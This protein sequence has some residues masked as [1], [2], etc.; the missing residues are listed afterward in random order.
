MFAEPE[1]LS[2]SPWGTDGLLSSFDFTR[3]CVNDNFELGVPTLDVESDRCRTISPEFG[4]SCSQS[5]NSSQYSEEF[6]FDIVCSSND[7]NRLISDHDYQSTSSSLLL[8][9]NFDLLDNL[10]PF[11]DG[12]LPYTLMNECEYEDSE[13]TNASSPPSPKAKAT[14]PTNPLADNTLWSDMSVD[15]QQIAIEY[16]TNI[17]SNELGLREQLDIIR[18][19]QPSATVSPADTEY[20]IDVTLLNDD[21]LCR[22]REYLRKAQ[23]N[24]HH[25]KKGRSKNN[26]NHQYDQSCKSGSSSKGLST[27][28]S[29]GTKNRTP[30]VPKEKERRKPL[31]YKNSKELRQIKKER[32]SG[33]FIR[34]EVLSLSAEM[35]IID[36]DSDIDILG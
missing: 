28:K 35:M 11:E 18:I 22:V 26:S 3:S 29:E 32:R 31:T 6:S 16:L 19:I 14:K 34:E 1:V 5:S 20:T 21:K 30:K 12:I 4:S 9:C 8:D 15:E 24:Q 7:A 2:T 25:E 23:R 13:V 17:I 33:L 27:T 10:S 36:E